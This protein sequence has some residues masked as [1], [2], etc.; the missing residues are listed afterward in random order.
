MFSLQGFG[1]GGERGEY[2]FKF[3]FVF[4][5]KFC[6]VVLVGF[7]GTGTV[8]CKERRVLGCFVSTSNARCYCN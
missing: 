8:P 3:L 1:G 2:V 4:H 5:N 6:S 7:G